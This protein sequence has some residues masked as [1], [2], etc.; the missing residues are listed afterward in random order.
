MAGTTVTDDG[1]VEQA[2]LRALDAVEPDPDLAS[3]AEML[4]YVRETMGTSKLTVFRA[5]FPEEAKAQAA[6]LAFEGAYHDLLS[7]ESVAPI[8][9][10]EEAIR[11][12]QSAGIKIALLT[13][14]SATTR[15]A[16]VEKLGWQGLADLLVC[17]SEGV[18][19][20]PYPDMILYALMHL[21]IDAVQNVAVV[22]DTVADVRS[23][24]AAGSH[25][26]AG[27]RTGADEETRLRAAGATHILSSIANLP[28][29]IAALS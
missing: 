10:A 15:D 14:F 19:G 5:L 13:G 16:L 1:L 22:G 4:A 2:F 20:R 23:G 27:V 29:A 18:R 24:L 12:L 26:V 8:P 21:G 7:S 25:F 6:N 11:N 9:G 3:R 28:E 17:P